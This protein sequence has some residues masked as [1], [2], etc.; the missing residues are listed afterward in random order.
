MIRFVPW[1]GEFI[2]VVRLKTIQSL[3]SQGNQHLS[4]TWIS[5][6]KC[7]GRGLKGPVITG[8]TLETE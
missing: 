4:V 8:M 6:M 2:S 1:A 7:K 5:I 3:E